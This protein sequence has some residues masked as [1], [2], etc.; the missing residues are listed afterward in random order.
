MP[1]INTKS[2]F[3]Q[4]HEMIPWSMRSFWL[5]DFVLNIQERQHFRD[6]TSLTKIISSKKHEILRQHVPYPLC[7]KSTSP[8]SCVHTQLTFSLPH[9]PIKRLPR[10]IL[11]GFSQ[12]SYICFPQGELYPLGLYHQ[13]VVCSHDDDEPGAD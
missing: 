1:N 7:S 8:K 13:C 10:V 5:W 12:K 2:T 4:N 11:K 9:F 3:Y 6:K